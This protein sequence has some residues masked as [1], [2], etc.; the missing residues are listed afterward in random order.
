M[1]AG[2]LPQTAAPAADRRPRV[3]RRLKAVLGWL[4][5]RLGFHRRLLAGRAVVVLFH[6]VDDRYPGNPITTTRGEFAAYL[7]FFERFFT[8]ISLAELLKRLER[9]DDLNADL[10]ITFDD[11]YLDNYGDAAPLLARHGLPACFFITT[12]FMGSDYVPWWDKNLGIR[13]E[14]MNWDQVRSLHA[15]GF[16][17]GVH[18]KNHVDL[19]Q[20]AGEAAVAEIVGSKQRLECELHTPIHF[21][22][23]PYGRR[24]QISEENRQAVREA[25]LSCCLS[26][27]GG[28][29]TSSDDPFRIKRIPITPWYVSPYHFGF[30]ALFWAG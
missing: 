27:F 3:K 7:K 28:T 12:D 2:R 5:F 11:G 19:S 21:F 9:G 20:V 24:H 4:I 13:S 16:E 10:V 18:T 23:Y 8:V 30:E 25:G 14:F 6:R 17:I 1:V 26:A 29:V 15:Q 22:T